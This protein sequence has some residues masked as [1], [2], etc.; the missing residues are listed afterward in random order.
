MAVVLIVLLWGKLHKN[1]G[2]R[3]STTI[4]VEEL[5][6]SVPPA[7]SGEGVAHKILKRSSIVP[8][9]SRVGLQLL[10]PADVTLQISCKYKFI[11]TTKCKPQYIFEESTKHIVFSLTMRSGKRNKYLIETGS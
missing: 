5:L 1:K 4:S 6:E 7:Q 11:V 3:G 9:P 2:G 10:W 8:I